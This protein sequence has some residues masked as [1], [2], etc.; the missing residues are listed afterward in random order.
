MT[1]KMMRM[2][3]TASPSSRGRT[4]D[5]NPYPS[6]ASL[7]MVMLTLA[8]STQAN[9][10]QPW[11]W[12]LARWEDSKIILCNTTAGAP[13]FVFNAIDLFPPPNPKPR[14]YPGSLNIQDYYMCP[15]S[16]PGKSYCNSPYEYYCAYWGCET[17]ATGWNPA[18]PDKFLKLT[19]TPYPCLNPGNRYFDRYLCPKRLMLTVQDP[20]DTS[21][22]MGRTWG[23][24]IH[25]AGKVYPPSL[26]QLPQPHSLR[27]LHVSHELC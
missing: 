17:L 3:L 18:V 12:I 26:R 2:I 6:I 14:G 4:G 23:F 8:S 1:S 19:V 21:W 25:L 16:N 24:R 9:P 15:S 22:L 7:L 11:K 5:P 20:T 27:Q 10:H 13:S